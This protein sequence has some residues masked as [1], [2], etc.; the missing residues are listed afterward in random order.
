[1]TGPCIVQIALTTMAE[2]FDSPMLLFPN[3]PLWP[4]SKTCWADLNPALNAS[5]TDILAKM[6]ADITFK[7]SN[8]PRSNLKYFDHSAT[9]PDV[10][11]NNKLRSQT[12]QGTCQNLLP[13]YSTTMTDLLIK[14]KTEII[15]KAPDHSQSLMMFIFY[16]N[17]WH[18]GNRWA[19]MAPEHLNICAILLSH[20]DWSIWQT[21]SAMVTVAKNI[22]CIQVWMD[23]VE[24]NGI[25]EFLI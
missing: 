24:G 7:R 21:I 2:L 16:F 6:G 1:M 23:I 12:L 15:S 3:A 25:L 4:S 13:Y 10:L 22:Y 18:L 8:A 19:E 14:L 17:D 5:M 11:A 20:K 9:M